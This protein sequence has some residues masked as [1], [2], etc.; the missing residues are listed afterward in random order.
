M[1]QLVWEGWIKA[2]DR[3]C[4]DGCARDVMGEMT[5]LMVAGSVLVLPGFKI[6]DTNGGHLSRAISAKAST[7]WLLLGHVTF[8]ERPSGRR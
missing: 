1:K 4:S 3:F 8:V 5:G 7:I 6:G 2:Q